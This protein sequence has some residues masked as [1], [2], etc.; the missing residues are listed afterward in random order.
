[1]KDPSNLTD[2]EKEA[3][4]EAV[5][6]ANPTAT[7]VEVGKDGT[8]TVTFPDGTKATIP[9]SKA[10]EEA[11]KEGVKA[12]EKTPVKDPSNLTDA[13]KEAVKEA[14]IKANPKLKD[15]KVKITIS[16][17]GDATIVYPDGKVVVIPASDLV[18]KATNNG[19]NDNSADGNSNAQD[20]NAKLGQRLANTGTTETN[21]GF[22][23]LGLGIL[24]GL[25]AARRRKNDKN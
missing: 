25:L 10:V 7:E 4:K 24:G 15:P 2:A 8:V 13:E 11:L 1:V 17:K 23:G 16:A 6:K 9:G 14:L 12:P 18:A 20:T 21:T 5:K 22:A 19:S 3:V